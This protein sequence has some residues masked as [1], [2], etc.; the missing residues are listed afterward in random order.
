MK[1]CRDLP[2]RM[3]IGLKTGNLTPVFQ[4]KLFVPPAHGN[5]PT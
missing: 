1:S 5:T 2:D 4:G 3:A